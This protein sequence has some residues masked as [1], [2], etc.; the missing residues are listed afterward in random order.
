MWL[1]SYNYVCSLRYVLSIWKEFS[2]K[3]VI[4]KLPQINMHFN[5]QLL[6]QK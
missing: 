1:I 5:Q 4:D 3:N 2:E 6:K